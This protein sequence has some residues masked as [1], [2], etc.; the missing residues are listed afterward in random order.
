MAW[1]V[2]MAAKLFNCTPEQLPP[3]L[4]QN[5]MSL[6]TCDRNGMAGYV[7]PG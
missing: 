3:E 4:Q 5:L 7:R 6:L 1:Q 2:R